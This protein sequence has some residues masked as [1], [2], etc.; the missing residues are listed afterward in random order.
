MYSWPMRWSAPSVL[1]VA[2]L[3]T[4]SAPALSAYPS[5]WKTV[6]TQNG[7]EVSWRWEK[8][9]NGNFEAELRFKNTTTRA[10][11]VSAR[12]FFT[13]R[14]GLRWLGAGLVFDLEPKQTKSGF[15]LGRSKLPAAFHAAPLEGGCQS[16]LVTS[17]EKETVGVGWVID[18]E[19]DGVLVSWRW[20]DV[21]TGR[22]VSELQLANLTNKPVRVSFQAWFSN[23]K[24]QRWLGPVRRLSLEALETLS[25]AE[26]GLE[27]LPVYHSLDPYSAHDRWLAST[28]PPESGGVA[29]LLV[30]MQP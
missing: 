15:E 20:R 12:P 3:A 7:V 23:Q 17:L 1:L 28:E 8:L 30:D 11:H 10:V 2:V 5:P 6:A 29:D 26:A 14:D 9:D 25:G 18:Q 22:P 19:T 4:L 24:N 27:F 21:G 16:L 13:T